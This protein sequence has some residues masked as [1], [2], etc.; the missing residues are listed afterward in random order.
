VFS[1]DATLS[2]AIVHV[3]KTKKEETFRE[4][5]QVDKVR[6]KKILRNRVIITTADG[7]QMLTI[8]PEDFAKRQGGSS[9]ARQSN[10]RL[11]ASP[12]TGNV[13]EPTGDVQSDVPPSPRVRT[14]SI[15]LKREQVGEALSDVD[16]LLDELQISPY[17]QDGQPAGFIVSKI[18]RRSILTRMGLRNGYAVTRL[19][20]QEITNADQAAQFFETLANG[21]DVSFQIQRSRGTRR[22]ARE[23]QLS[24]E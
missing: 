11:Q 17:L 6:I 24:I 1:G 18:P 3:Q 22:R 15:K 10:R 8:N 13:R 19:N 20:D 21:G 23:I 4:G 14:L 7:D 5:D 9:A 16:E 12:G 2:R